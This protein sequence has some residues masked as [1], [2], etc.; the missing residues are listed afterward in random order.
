MDHSWLLNFKILCFVPVTLSTCSKRVRLPEGSSDKHVSACKTRSIPVPSKSF[1]KTAA[2]TDRLIIINFVNHN[3]NHV[4]AKD[5]R[6][7]NFSSTEKSSLKYSFSY[8]FFF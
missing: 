4:L 1:L 2:P 3:Y 6:S 5:S 7:C 8:V